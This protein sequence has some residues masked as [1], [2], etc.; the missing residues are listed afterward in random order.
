MSIKMKNTNHFI[1]DDSIK[2]ADS[3][4]FDDSIASAATYPAA[5]R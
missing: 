4:Q 5:L 2:F 1:S 3:I